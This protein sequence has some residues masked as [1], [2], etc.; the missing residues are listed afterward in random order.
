MFTRF[1]NMPL[2][3]K[4]LLGM[5]VGIIVGLVFHQLGWGQIVTD[6]IKP[7][8][9]I[10]MRLLKFI[11]IPLIVIS[12]MKGVGDLGSIS[13]LSKLGLKT[14]FLFLITTLVCIVVG[15]VLVEVIAP[16]KLVSAE[17]AAQM[18]QAYQ[19]TTAEKAQIAAEMS[20]VSPLQPLVDV[21]PDNLI[22]AT[23]T[24]NNMLQVIFIAIIGGVAILM[25]GKERSQALMNVIE[26]AN[27]VVLKIIDIIMS[28][29]P[30]GMVALMAGMIVDSAGNLNLL[31]ALGLYSITVVLGLLLIIFLVYPIFIKLFSK[32]PLGK[33]FKEMSPVQLLAFSTSSSAATL[34]LTMETVQTKLGVSAQT[35][36]FVLPVGTTINMGGTS[37]YQAI[38]AIFIAQ[39]LGIDLS[40]QE[41][42]ILV[43]TTTVSAIGTP[44]V[45]GG[46]VVILL[47]VLASIGVPAEGLALIMGVDRPLDMLRTVVNVTG[48][49]TVAIIVDKNVVH[50]E[51]Q[52]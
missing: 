19:S 41:M 40:W 10:F 22:G 13:S 52:A 38:A 5:V 6:W 25:V 9:E 33:F 49:A 51:I 12:L 8:G 46:S 1:K 24:N 26:S 7:F 34:P 20:N 30:I 45:P 48:D 2:Y 44:G 16:G 36:S 35:S 21:F 4:I 28:Y 11:A 3:V 29:A 37:C 31:G 42:L 43:T 27:H 39:V 23:A 14:I 32:M 17:S 15:L 50:D 18:Q 47:M